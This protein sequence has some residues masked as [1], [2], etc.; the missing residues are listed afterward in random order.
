MKI[1]HLIPALIASFSG[2][3][4]VSA[5]VNHPVNR[6]ASSAL[7]MANEIPI[8]E[9]IPEEAVDMR[10]LAQ[11][12]FSKAIP[13]LPRPEFL[14]GTMAGDAGF[15]PLGFV[16]SEE[17]LIRFREAE[18]KHS[19]L[20]MLAAAGWPLS[21]VFQSKIASIMGMSPMLDG[22]GRAPTFLNG[23]NGISAAFWIMVLGAAA[24]VEV[25]GLGK[26]KKD[27]GYIPGDF[28]WDPLGL[29]PEEPEMQKLMQLKE[30][31]HGR[32]AMMAVLFYTIEE[33]VSGHSIIPSL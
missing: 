3:H 32:T 13:V 10:S 19:R 1:N 11:I 24:F 7:K 29:Y 16:K 22:A 18:V 30:I 17:D 31:K 15:D 8:L 23:F 33:L 4:A 20:A 27:S 26:V 28:G 25:N 9:E 14:S 5:F 6:P 12:R 2:S 21:E